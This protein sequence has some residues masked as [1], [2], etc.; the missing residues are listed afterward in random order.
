[1]KRL[2]LFAAWEPIGGID[3]SVL[4][5][6]NELSKF[7][8]VLFYMDNDSEIP[9][10]LQEMTLY[11]DAKRHQEYDFGSYKRL[12]LWAHKN[13]NL[14]HYDII[15]LVNDSMYC[16]GDLSGMIKRMEIANTD[17]WGV[18][19]KKNHLGTWFIG[20]RSRVFLSGAFFNFMASITHQDEKGKVCELYENGLLRLAKK[21]NWSISYLYELRGHQ[22]YNDVK[23][24]FLN[25]LPLMKKT[26][27]VR[28]N[29]SLGRRVNF[30]LNHISGVARA[31][32]LQNAYRIYG[33][34]RV[35]KNLG[36]S[37]LGALWRNIIYV[38]KKLL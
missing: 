15:Y 21:S 23:R 32:I 27:I 28:H 37:L 31:A 18:V 26:A 13:L 22:I 8:D 34:E 25:G 30:I 7:G 9:K 33:A 10:K 12:F 16:L 6:I 36:L 4:M 38:L 1:M 5:Y 20:M 17:I 24:L 35:D 29:G 14:S 3:D 2:F 19:K 11:S